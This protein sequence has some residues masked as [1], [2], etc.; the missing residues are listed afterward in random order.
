MLSARTLACFLASQDDPEK[1]LCPHESVTS[2][3]ARELRR[4]TKKALLL[5]RTKPA[6]RRDDHLGHDLNETILRKVGPVEGE[7]G[8]ESPPDPRSN[9]Q[10][11][12]DSEDGQGNPMSHRKLHKEKDPKSFTQSLFDTTPLKQLQVYIPD[13]YLQWS[14]CLKRAEP[15]AT[16]PSDHWAARKDPVPRKKHATLNSNTPPGSDAT[17]SISVN[18]EAVQHVMSTVKYPSATHWSAS[19]NQ[20]DKKGKR[21]SVSGVTEKQ[22]PLRN[23]CEAVSSA[24]KRS[25]PVAATE[26]SKSPISQQGNEPSLTSAI[27]GDLEVA[28]TAPRLKDRKRAVSWTGLES[29]IQ[30]QEHKPSIELFNVKHSQRY[31]T[32]NQ[33]AAHPR[34]IPGVSEQ[35]THESWKPAETLS[36]LT[37][38][39]VNAL[40][41]MVK[42]AEPSLYHGRLQLRS[43]GRT[44]TTYLQPTALTRGSSTE[45]QRTRAF[46][47]QSLNYVLGNAAPLL[48]SFLCRA[49]CGVVPDVMQTRSTINA[50]DL[51]YQFRNLMEID[52]HPRTILPSLW[53][54]TGVLFNAPLAHSNP[55]CSDLRAGT[56]LLKAR[57]DHSSTDISDD[58]RNEAFLDD[59]DAAHIVKIVLAA[60]GATIPKSNP[61]TWL[62]VQ[63]LRASGH[64]APEV[65]AKTWDSH[66]VRSLLETMDA[67]EDEAAL[68]LTTR[69]VRAISARRCMSEMAKNKK[70]SRRHDS[71][72]ANVDHGIINSIL[73]YFTQ[74]EADSTDATEASKKTSKFLASKQGGVNDYHHESP[75][76]TLTVRWS[77]P[78]VTV[79]WFRSVLLKEW[80]GKAEVAKWGAVGGAIEMMSSFCKSHC[81]CWLYMTVILMKAADEHYTE[82][83]LVPETFH[84]P[85]L[86]ERLEPME[87]PLEWL[88]SQGNTNT[89]HLLSYSF[90]FPPSALVTYFRAIN[91]SAMFKA[92][93][94]SITTTRMVMQMTFA[95]GGL[96]DNRES[97]L[98]ERLN[99]ALTNYLVLEIRRDDVLTCALNQLWR[100]ERRELMRPLKVRMGMEEGEE[101][102]DH[103]GVQQEFFRMAIGEALNPEYGKYGFDCTNMVWKAANSVTCAGLFTT[104]TRTR[105]SWFQPCSLEPLYK[106]ELLGLLTSLAIYNG[107]TLP[108]TFPLALYRKLL[109]IPVTGLEH[110]RDGW[111]ELAKGLTD[112]LT[113]ADG[114]VEDVFMRSYVFSAEALGSTLIVDM[115]RIGPN[116][117]WPATKADKGKG[118]GKSASFGTDQKTTRDSLATK[119]S[120]GSPQSSAEDSDG[121]INLASPAI[122]VDDLRGLKDA[123]ASGEAAQILRSRTNSVASQAGMVTNENR[124]QYVKDYIFWLTDKSIRPQYEA[125]ARGFFVCL[126]RKALS[127]F[128]P[129]ALQ[130]VVEGIQEIDIDALEQTA[131][132]ENGYHVDHRIIKDFW[133]VVRQ[134]SPEKVRQLLEFVTA[135]DRIPVNGIRS[136]LFV[137]Q[138]N[139]TSDEVSHLLIFKP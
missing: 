101:G 130:S 23:D 30:L 123:P 16:D 51:L 133:H 39:N 19:A 67:F 135:S 100:R 6:L 3:E 127:I 49:A 15:P 115:E 78:A 86:S 117:I 74:D 58:L 79:E 32:S 22:R 80:N 98:L 12:V 108:I 41:R 112:L 128:T 54:A 83:G 118:K 50:E 53:I 71:V 72:P 96:A 104:D 42:A 132:Y 110:I 63:K 102:V 97:R 1:G 84:T 137:I 21:A 106:F 125:F 95:E 91:H 103:G 17:P 35:P 60:L 2:A 46:G 109:G 68:T 89:V 73:G 14:P 93:E 90:L 57:Q 105:M 138:R 18:A 129:N 55:R 44:D 26:A 85:F 48:E 36:H 45:V 120:H 66:L 139:G 87:M 24:W 25:K 20:R 47:V 8:F 33:P 116:D 62:A 65:L 124:E 111:P 81:F 11:R 131:R 99:V 82:L 107:L 113:W 114:T 4:L 92:F 75:K 43:I 27:D 34:N 94:A 126:D 37:P 77:F 38:E 52:H 28:R 122:S 7:T 76:D 70:T 31:A 134:F 121:W 9:V 136:I 59:T 61:E 5:T 56:A 88:N 119:E 29:Q 10:H 13:Q 69:L 40:V 64:V